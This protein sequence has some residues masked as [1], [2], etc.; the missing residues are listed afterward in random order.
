MDR[1]IGFIGAGNMGSCIVRG[2]LSNGYPQKLIYVSNPT[3]SKLNSLLKVFPNI[4][5]SISNQFVTE[6]S[7]IIVICTKP[8]I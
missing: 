6:N 2:L 7:E 5:I 4:N 1:T 8:G 3:K